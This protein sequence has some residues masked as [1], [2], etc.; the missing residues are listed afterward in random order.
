MLQAS[1]DSI[2]PANASVTAPGGLALPAA[3]L[4][5]MLRFTENEARLQKIKDRY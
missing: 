4:P 1:E 3:E 5:C 2:R